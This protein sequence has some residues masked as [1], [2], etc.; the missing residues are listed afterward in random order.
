[1][2]EETGRELSRISFHPFPQQELLDLRDRVEAL[3]KSL[4]SPEARKRA[5]FRL[6]DAL[7]H[8]H[9]MG[10]REELQRREKKLQVTLPLSSGSV[11]MMPLD[12]KLHR[13]LIALAVERECEVVDI[14]R[15]LVKHVKLVKP[16]GEI[17]EEEK[18][19]G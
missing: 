18:K 1:V 16:P 19:H 15:E 9:A 14:L 4:H 6:A 3:A 12:D 10:E 2:D 13:Q 8:L 5:Y 11:I 7:D 17:K